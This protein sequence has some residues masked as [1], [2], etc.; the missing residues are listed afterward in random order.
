MKKSKLAGDDRRI[1][2]VVPPRRGLLEL[3]M[4]DEAAVHL[5]EALRILRS[6]PV[7]R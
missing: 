4:K 3:G 6:R 2:L 7:A 1:L 5:R